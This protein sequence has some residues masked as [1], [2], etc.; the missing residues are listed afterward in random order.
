M[1]NLLTDIKG[2]SAEDILPLASEERDAEPIENGV[3]VFFLSL[4]FWSVKYLAY[5]LFTAYNENCFLGF[6]IMSIVFVY[7]VKRYF[8]NDNV[9]AWKVKQVVVNFIPEN[10]F[11]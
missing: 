8:W 7:A 2:I 9:S 4:R 5:T 1:S 10:D 11:F 3:G 6:I